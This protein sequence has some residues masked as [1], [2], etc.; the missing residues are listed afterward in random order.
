M[1]NQSP[2]LYRV[3][4]LCHEYL[5]HSASGAAPDRQMNFTHARGPS[6]PSGRLKAPRKAAGQM[7]LLTVLS[8]DGADMTHEVQTGH[9]GFIS[10][11]WRPLRP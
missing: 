7:D 6:G 1:L 8:H 10:L 3:V 9:V 11:L 2:P 4:S 5:T